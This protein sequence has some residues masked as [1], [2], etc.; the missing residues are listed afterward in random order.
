MNQKRT[1]MIYKLSILPDA[2]KDRK[3]PRGIGLPTN[4]KIK[5]LADDLKLHE[6]KKSNSF[7]IQR[8]QLRLLYRIRVGNYRVAYS[9]QEEEI[10]FI[11]VNIAHRKEVY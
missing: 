8:T 9:I 10:T 5:L 1:L 2:A 3:L 11:V 4:K 6:Y 7:D